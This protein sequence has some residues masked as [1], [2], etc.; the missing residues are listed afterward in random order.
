LNDTINSERSGE[1]EW[2]RRTKSNN[3]LNRSANSAAFIENLRGFGI[4]CAHRLIRALDT[5][6][7]TKRVEMRGP[8]LRNAQAQVER[9]NLIGGLTTHS[10]GARDS[11]SFM[12][13]FCGS[14]CV[15]IAR[16]RLMQ[17]LDA[18]PLARSYVVPTL[19]VAAR[20]IE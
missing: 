13:F 9:V 8:K 12:L 11:D 4:A 10:T 3:S 15:L 5:L 7:V 14:A 20:F 1:A 19:L 18:A 2:A 6:C 16:A 17:A